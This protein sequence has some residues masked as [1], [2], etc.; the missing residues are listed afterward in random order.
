VRNTRLLETFVR[1]GCQQHFVNGSSYDLQTVHR[2]QEI[3]QQRPID[4][5]FIDGDHRYD[6][7]QADFN[8]FSP[9]VR[10]GGQIAF[11]DIVPDFKTQFGRDTGR[12][13]GDVPKLWQEVKQGPD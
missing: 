3:L 6:G 2:V 1:S 13:A 7:A 9:L 10:S 5:L 12:W 4:V 8:L 11:H